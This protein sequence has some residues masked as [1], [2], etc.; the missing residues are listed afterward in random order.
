MR[1]LI[2]WMIQVCRVMSRQW[3]PQDMNTV[4]LIQYHGYRV[5]TH[6]VWT[7]DGYLLRMHRIP[8][9]LYSKSVGRPIFLQHGLNCASDILVIRSPNK[10]LA[11]IL[12]DSGYDVWM[13]NSRGNPY[14]PGYVSTFNQTFWNFSF[15]EMG[16]YDL[17]A[18]IDYILNLTKHSNLSFV[19]HSLGGAIAFVL[20]S[21]RPEY[22]NKINVII[23]F[24][25]SVYVSE[26][27]YL[28]KTYVR[29][30][31]KLAPLVYRYLGQQKY[32]IHGR[33]QRTKSKIMHLFSECSENSL[34]KGEC[35]RNFM[36]HILT[37]EEQFDV[38]YILPVRILT[39]C[40]TSMKNIIH[41]CQTAISNKFHK[42]DYGSSKNLLYYGTSSPPLYNFQNITT[43]VALYVAPY[44]EVVSLKSSRRL[45]RDFKNLMRFFIVDNNKFNHRDFIFA[46]D[47]KIL[48]YNNVLNLLKECVDNYSRCILSNEVRK[49]RDISFGSNTDLYDKLSFKS[50]FS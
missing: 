8:H 18:E 26:S 19:G 11:Y 36:R 6:E 33:D 46:R 4:N 35:V 27:W 31:A 10:D 48:V 2:L 15:H 3:K 25:P 5:E 20:L 42:F 30:L 28:K 29:I 23:G 47:A 37:D 9:N 14:S 24:A 39:K 13:G 44:D 45:A 16:V 7:D 38:E 34:K 1:H 17:A 50:I 43:P 32:F 22:N 21:E 49:R 40:G 12:S 41:I